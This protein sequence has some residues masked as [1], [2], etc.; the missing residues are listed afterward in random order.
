MNFFVLIFSTWISLSAHSAEQNSSLHQAIQSKNLGQ[1]TQLIEQGQANVNDVDSKFLPSV[2]LVAQVGSL[3]ILKYFLEK[4]V[5]KDIT[6]RGKN[7]L[8]VAYDY[9]R[10]DM[11]QFLIKEN[12]I[13]INSTDRDGDTLLRNAIIRGSLKHIKFFLEN[14]M[15]PRLQS[16]SYN[17]IFAAYSASY[18]LLGN[19]NVDNLRQNIL[20][21][22]SKH[23][24]DL[25]VKNKEGFSLLDLASSKGSL[26]DVKFLLGIGLQPGQESLKRARQLDH[27]EN[28]QLIVEAIEKNMGIKPA[29]SSCARAFRK[30]LAYL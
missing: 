15:D 8:W 24:I 7:I 4:G 10:W 21:E 25:D 2:F 5:D 14:G 29:S 6:Y 9:N 20:E 18:D 30:A 16:K 11:V 26:K 28:S 22:L 23:D 27:T 1:V 17:H 12:I 13:D 3:P 19:R